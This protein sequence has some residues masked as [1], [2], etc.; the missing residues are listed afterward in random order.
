MSVW[1]TK[2]R[3]PAL[4]LTLAA[5]VALAAPLQASE[6]VKSGGSKQEGIGVL[7]GMTIGALAGGPF[8]AVIGAATGG[9]LGERYHKQ[10]EDKKALAA[11]LS[12]TEAAKT[13]LQG[14]LAATREEGEK[15]GLAVDRGRELEASF[16]FRTADS[17][18]SDEDVVR[19]QKLGALA[20]AVG[21]VKVRVSGYADPRG[22]EKFNAALSEQRADAVAHVLI[23]SGVDVSQL[24]VEARGEA[25]SN[26][27]E[28]DLDGYAF[29]RRVTVKIEHDA[30]PAAVARN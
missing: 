1:T 22:S 26:T 27:A 10:A 14:D 17:T 25:D 24:V 20:G 21:K 6:R 2:L 3:G 30:G 4:G 11:S 5:A 7:S 29:D 23:Q 18:L 15:L 13:Q 16:G 28:G 8:G 19:L 9:I 12:S